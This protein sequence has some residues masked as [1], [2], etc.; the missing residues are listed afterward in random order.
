MVAAVVAHP[1]SHTKERRDLNLQL[2]K[3]K[4]WPAYSS[5]ASNMSDYSRKRIAAITNHSAGSTGS[6]LAIVCL[7]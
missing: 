7:A 2:P 6:D 5:T 4:L 3:S 1:Q